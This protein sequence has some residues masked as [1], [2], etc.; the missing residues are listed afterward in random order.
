MGANNLPIILGPIILIPGGAREKRIGTIERGTIMKKTVGED[1]ETDWRGQL[2]Y[3][4]QEVEEGSNK[5]FHDIPD[6]RF[7][8]PF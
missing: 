8:G 3:A 1:W 5:K 4:I 7:I 2:D 6:S